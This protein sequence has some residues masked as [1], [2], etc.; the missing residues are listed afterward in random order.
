MT[1]VVT[2]TYYAWYSVARVVNLRGLRCTGYGSCMRQTRHACRALV[3]DLKE[4][5]HLEDQEG[6]R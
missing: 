6:D 4:S 1:N 3:R 2:Y 5:G